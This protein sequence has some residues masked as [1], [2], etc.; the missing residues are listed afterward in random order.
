M[1]VSC[2]TPPECG[3]IFVS[4]AS[5]VAP[6]KFTV[7]EVEL[8]KRARA[9]TLRSSALQSTSPQAACITTMENPDMGSVVLALATVVQAY[10]EDAAN[11][12]VVRLV[13]EQS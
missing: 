2:M 7:D 9:K 5:V 13:P 11:H 3:E 12:G 10:A 8:P 6:H 1:T 4:E